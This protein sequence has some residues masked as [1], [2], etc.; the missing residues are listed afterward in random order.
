ME[1]KGADFSGESNLQRKFELTGEVDYVKLQLAFSS[2]DLRRASRI[3]LLVQTITDRTYYLM[4][5]ITAEGYLFIEE[6]REKYAVGAKIER[7]FLNEARHSIYYLR[8]GA[9]AVLLIDGEK[10]DL[11]PIINTRALTGALDLGSNKVQIGGIN[12]TDPRFASFKSYSG[13][14]SSEYF[15]SISFFLYKILF[16]WWS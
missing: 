13:C 5:G 1:E 16:S 9:D 15:L 14:L 6:D 12:T 11:T 2:N 7:Y 10:T 3:M 4:V 8:K